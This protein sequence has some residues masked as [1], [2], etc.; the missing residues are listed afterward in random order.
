MKIVLI[1]DEDTFTRNVFA[2]TLERRGFDVRHSDDAAS[3]R[4]TLESLPVDL[5]VVDGQLS[6]CDSVQ[7]VRDL[8]DE[9]IEAPI[10]Y[11]SSVFR[12]RQDQYQRLTE[13]CGVRL[14]LHKPIS[15]VEFC[16]QVEN[17]FDISQETKWWPANGD[18]SVIE[19]AESARLA[20][21]STLEERL[22]ELEDR[23]TEIRNERRAFGDTQT[24]VAVIRG[25]AS[26]YGFFEV[27]RAAGRIEATFE[28]LQDDAEQ[29]SRM[30]WNRA[31][32]ALDDAIV[33]LRTP[34]TVEFDTEDERQTASILVV[35]DDPE[36]LEQMERFGAE[37]LV[38]VV[39]ATEP[40][41]VLDLSR[42]PTLDA[43]LVDVDLGEGFD[44]F[45]FVRRL[46]ERASA[47]RLPL[48][49][50]ADYG[51]VPDRVVASHLGASVFV[52][53]PIDS[54]QFNDIVHRLTSMA[55]TGKPVVLIVEQD[56]EFVR[57]TSEILAD[58]G[59]EP[60]AMDDT[61][62]V[63]QR[64][65]E[66]SPHG[67][68]ANV[69]MPG[70]GGFDLCRMIRAMPRWHDLP[71][72]LVG[73]RMDA[74][75]RIA[76]F[77]SGADDYILSPPIREELLARLQVRIE[78]MRL[79]REQA[80]V[81]ML[82]G[83]LTRRPFMQRVNARI[84]EVRR[85]GRVLALGLLDLD[86]F[87]D[88]NDTFGHIAGDRVLAGLGRLLTNRFRME[89]LR[90]RWGGEEFMVAL[91]DEDADTAKRVL[92]RTLDEF[93]QMEFVGDE[94]ERFS[95]TFSAGVAVFPDDGEDFRELLTV[96]DRRLYEA[97][98]GGR[99]QIVAE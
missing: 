36:F 51:S 58:A 14:V 26:R 94:G 50:I 1:V 25:A 93:S 3:A 56:S 48:G 78:R 95:V 28:R 81:D 8:R 5:I 59:M 47:N 44:T 96:A 85:G 11:L 79:L 55:R 87:K 77:R 53:K 17:I 54:T 21:A 4:E 10:V 97:K 68:V 99:N 80:Q 75:T 57:E 70:I 30:L 33:A 39:T 9:G 98:S 60:R 42:D 83:L 86:R 22:R 88:V 13:E 76:A 89:D 74:E 72:L 73:D 2:E 24:L 43:L 46:R 82:T 15:P 69:S 23:L 27:S 18:T 90:A 20:Y 37:N 63:I 67:L 38:R 49:F 52:E 6:D 34:R 12:Q 45:A 92:Q 29:S 84:S 40:A 61:H 71:I 65:D 62:E 19:E 66:I 16:A 7:F 32:D 64:L 31:F 91:V 41:D 35:D